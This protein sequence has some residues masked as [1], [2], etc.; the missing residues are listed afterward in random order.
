LSLNEGP[1]IFDDQFKFVNSY[2]KKIIESGLLPIGLLTPDGKFSYE[3]LELCDGFLIPGGTQVYKFIYEI[4]YHSIKNNIPVLGICLGA[5]AI[6]IFSGF[7]DKLN[8]EE[9]LTYE[10][11]NKIYIHAHYNISRD[12]IDE[13]RHPIIIIKGTLLYDIYQKDEINVVSFHSYDF[14]FVEN[15]FITSAYA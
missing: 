8:I 6:S 14:K 12:T 11:L 15:N 3:M 4:I 1:S 10:K 2:T 7:F 9:E 5:E 13:A